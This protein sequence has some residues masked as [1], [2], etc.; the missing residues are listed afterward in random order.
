MRVVVVGAGG[1]GGTIG[2]RLHQSGYEV[3][4]VARGAHGE[5]VR[6]R[7][8]T[9]ATPEER[10]TLRIPTY[11]HPRDVSWTHEDVVVLAA[12]SQDTEAAARDLALAAG[13][14]PV[15]AAQNGVANERTLA[16]WFPDV[17]GMCVMMPTAH[18]EPGVVVAHSAAATGI[19]DLG[20]FPEGT[21]DVDESL[22]AALRGSRI[23]SVPRPD[24][25]RWKY[26]KLLNN[27]G[28]AV[29]AL[30]GRHLDSEEARR[31]LDLL[32]EEA[33]AV[34]AASGIVPVTDREDD[35]RRADHL[36]LRP[37]AG[38]PRAGGS[39]W[40]S[41]QRRSGIETDFLNGEIAL[42]GRLHG[43][44]TPANAGLQRLM[45]ESAARAA[46]PGTMTPAALLAALTR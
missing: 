26:R 11:T 1:I 21:D 31:V 32:A 43:V 19:L 17:H 22:A 16:R 39:T 9:F 25:M 4:L 12:K 14:V 40:Q 34:L 35:V 7:G 24:I 42:L 44:P 10:V 23:E 46:G 13:R 37:V 33:E 20:R 6:E 18:L 15:V 28:N 30:C 36:Q 8:L 29:Q 38:E 5:A 2:A 3:A 45:R 41:L 27:L